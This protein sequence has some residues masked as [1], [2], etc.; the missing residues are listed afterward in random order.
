MRIGSILFFVFIFTFVSF[1]QDAQCLFARKQALYV[2]AGY[3]SGKRIVCGIHVQSK[4]SANLKIHIKVEL[5]KNWVLVD[6]SEFDLFLDTSKHEFIYLDGKKYEAIQY[7]SKD[8]SVWINFERPEKHESKLENG[9][10]WVYWSCTYA[11][12]NYS[13]TNN[14]LKKY[15]RVLKVYYEK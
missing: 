11:T 15:N 2:S 8:A 5:L 9:M 1:S 7:R 3:L 14:R 10:E 12:M 4:D 6:S 13:S